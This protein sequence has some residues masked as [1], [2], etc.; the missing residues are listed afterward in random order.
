MTERSV[1][2]WYYD[3]TDAKAQQVADTGATLAWLKAGGDRGVAW[4]KDP[5]PE[6]FENEQWDD[7]YLRPLTARGI[8]CRPWVY[9]WPV[10]ADKEV[11][12]TVL[13]AR[14]SD[15]VGLNPETE[16]RVQSPHSP[17][18][19]LAQGNA[20]AAAWVRDLKARTLARFGRV[21]RLWVSSCPSWSDFPYEGFMAECDGAHP[22]HYWPDELM[23]DDGETGSERGEDMV[24]AH[25]R[26]AGKAKPM[27]AILTA[28]REYDDAGVVGLA[29]NAL[30]DYPDLAGFSAWEAGNRAF[31]ADAM[32]RAYALLPVDNVVRVE[33]PFLRMWRTFL[34]PP[35]A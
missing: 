16:W 6:G 22:Q 15:D 33:S 4:I 13:A 8:A 10:D 35:A 3:G 30:G 11:V 20:Y 2:F 25:L 29:Q 9:N 28:C 21:P 24:E 17:Y 27:V 19:T 7:A 31:Q 23:A 34:T 14:W 12:L 18:N 32:R 1:Y 26:R 5:A